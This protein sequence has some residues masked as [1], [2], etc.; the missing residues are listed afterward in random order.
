MGA[1]GRMVRGLISSIEAAGGCSAFCFRNHG[2]ASRQALSALVMRPFFFDGDRDIVAD[3]AANGAGYVGN[4]FQHSAMISAIS[5][6]RLGT[7]DSNH[8]EPLRGCSLELYF[9]LNG[10]LSMANEDKRKEL[11]QKVTTLVETRFAGDFKAAFGHYDSN[12]DGAIDKDEL[13]VLLT[14]AGI[15]NGLTRWAWVSGIMAE[16]DKDGDGA[17]SWAEF[18]AVFD[19]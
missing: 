14:D 10:V 3:A 7:C 8:C 6:D 9:E 13:K 2:S 17:I 15:G 4:D 19:D 1:S 5:T 18:A 12:H 11:A 16:L